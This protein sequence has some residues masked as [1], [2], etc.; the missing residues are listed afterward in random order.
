LRTVIQLTHL[1]DVTYDCLSI[2]SACAHSVSVYTL[3]ST[4]RLYVHGMEAHS[5]RRTKGEEDGGMSGVEG[6][7]ERNDASK[8]LTDTVQSGHL[9]HS[10]RFISFHLTSPL[11]IH[12]SIHHPSTLS[13]SLSPSSPHC[14][15]MDLDQPEASS[16]TSFPPQQHFINF[17][18]DSNLPG[19][20]FTK[21]V[22]A[23][24]PVHQIVQR[25]MEKIGGSENVS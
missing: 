12:T 16:S 15:E 6:V 7:R 2:S 14:I 5:V 11:F 18:F 20:R 25:L 9:S 24:A 1:F 21:L 19:E 4:S 22:E 8:G 23:D 3:Q 17:V 10:L 13:T